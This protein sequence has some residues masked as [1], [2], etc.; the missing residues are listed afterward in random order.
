MARRG[1]LYSGI[2]LVSAAVLM[3]EL[4]LTRLF[5]VAQWYHFAFLSVSV[6][7]LGYASSG[8]LLSLS[9]PE[10]RDRLDAVGLGFPL[11]ILA[12]FLIANYLPFDSYRLA[13]EPIQFVYLVLYY[14]ALV[15]P[16]GFGGWIVSRWL[17]ALP[18]QS[19]LVYAANLAG[20]ALGSLSL[21]GVLPLVGGEGAVAL[22]ASV[23]AL[24]VGLIF[25]AKRSRG[26]APARLSWVALTVCA[27]SLLLAWWQ[28]PWMALRI[29]PYKGL[30]QALRAP[31]THR[32]YQAW[33]V[34]SRLD[35][36]EGKG[37][38]SAPG[39]SLN[40][41]G[42]LPP[43]HGLT[44]DAGN[45]SPMTRR[46][47]AEDTA[48]LSYLPS[49]LPYILRP[50]AC[51]LII[52]PRGGLDVA[53]ALAHGA[54]DI[55]VV[56]DNPLVAEIVGQ[57]YADFLGGLYSGVTVRTEGGRSALQR[58]QETFDIIQFSLAESYHPLTS[59]TYSLSENYLYTVEAFERAL[60]RLD[61]EGILVITRWLQDPPSES[62]RAGALTVA[63]LERAGVT[64]PSRHLLAF[65]SWSTMTILASPSPFGGEDIARIVSACNRLG[66][67][68]VYYPRMDRSEANR[69]NVLP[70]PVYYEDFQ[71][72]LH[73]QERAALFEN[74]FYDV[75]PPTDNRPFF[76]HYFR[77][78]QVPRIVAQL[79]KTWQP[80][81]GS[82]FLVILVLL[83]VAVLAS[84][85]LV[86]L[87]LAWRAERSPL[88]HA[89]WRVVL[90]FAAL[91]LGYLFIELPLM[92]Q[93]I[94]YLGHA[95][96]SFVVV[97]SALM[98]FSGI[99][100]FLSPRLSLR[101]ALLILIGLIGIYPFG[102]R[103]LFRATLSLPRIARVGI[104][105]PSLLP[106]GVFMGVPFAGG[107]R[108]VERRAPGVTPWIWAIN[109]SASVISSVLAAVLA[110]SWGYH[111]VLATAGL[112][113]LGAMW[114]FWPLMKDGEGISAPP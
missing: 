90:Y 27:A 25:L 79:G 42:D 55:V 82:G 18:Q 19:G 23:G 85:I 5:A 102:L 71:K 44:V 63:A 83:V 69:Y 65:R 31:D 86:V 33:N 50:N 103:W 16:F 59:G 3:F 114:A 110:L 92:Q 112:C 20:S 100:S 75:T 26:V 61:E 68:L 97:L 15:I 43:Q 95:T 78:R 60:A 99:G 64:D 66:Y 4:T 21:L 80:F 46:I 39:L 10:R 49:S 73:R 9:S 36:V 28:P 105:T 67:D 12:S 1:Y 22:A 111:A 7:L 101:T 81:G 93:F 108:R 106:L 2:A 84:V 113:Y 40:Y 37:I 57:R 58:G 96:F 41:R 35:V 89:R 30:R 87:P 62:I 6:A 34:Y 98:L 48:F 72:L 29:S 13:L 76:G 47:G 52:S 45:L 91:G 74:K 14:L 32:T 107:L 56:E 51:A 88:G 109:G 94:L 24:G 77:W 70:E 54:Q 8:T 53:V 11:S 38:H 104:A 17:S